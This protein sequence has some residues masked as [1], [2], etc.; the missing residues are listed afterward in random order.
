LT[1]D[2]VN[3][4]KLDY[5]NDEVGSLVKVIYEHI[6]TLNHY[7]QREKWFTGDISHELRTPMMVISSSVELLKQN[8]V[9][10]EQK[11]QLLQRIDDAVKN[12]N[13]L[14]NTFLLLAR[15]KVDDQ[16]GTAQCNLSEKTHQ[17]VESL[18]PY[19]KSKEIKFN[20]ITENPVVL[21]INQALYA[22]VLTNLVKNAIFNTEKGEIR[23]I[24]EKN[25]FQ[26]RD[27]GKGLPDVVKQFINDGDVI[28]MT[29]NSNHLG[30][31]LSI[32]KRVCEREK[33]SITAYDCEKGGAGFTIYF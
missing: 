3:A 14:I 23:V 29:R 10:A 2:N 31:G 6:N 26:V 30:L 24:L 9:T 18:R 4:I 27:T 20:I 7:L 12:I 1:V 22:I 5:A 13:E 15:G 32:V 17:V 8:T 16:D 11:T 25:G 28:T 19:V 21:P 33:W